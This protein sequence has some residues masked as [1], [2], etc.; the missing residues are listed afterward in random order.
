MNFLLFLLF[1]EFKKKLKYKYDNYKC[2]FMIFLSKNK[3]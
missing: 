3:L 2:K 1:Y